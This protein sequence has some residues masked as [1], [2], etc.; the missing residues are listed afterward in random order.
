[1]NYRVLCIEEEA[2]RI[3]AVGT[4]AANG[5]PGAADRRWTTTEVRRAIREGDRFYVISPNTGHEAD[6]QVVLG[7]IVGARDDLG[8]EC[9]RD[10]RSCRWR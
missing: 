4:G 6:L 7:E 9:L 8:E 5:A 2:R 3:I 10:L 1:M